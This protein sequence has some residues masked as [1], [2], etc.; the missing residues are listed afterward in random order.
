MAKNRI[1]VNHITEISMKVAKSIVL[2]Y[3]RNRFLPETILKTL[4]TSLIHPYTNMVEKQGKERIKIITKIF[5]L[6]KEAMIFI[7]FQIM[8]CNID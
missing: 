7:A 1:F 4:Y 8:L 3:K 6:Q 5:V 2:L